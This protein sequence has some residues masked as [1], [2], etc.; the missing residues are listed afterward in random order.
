MFF[1]TGADCSGGWDGWI[2]IWWDLWEFLGSFFGGKLEA[3]A[4]Q[5]FWGF[6]RKKVCQVTLFESWNCLKTIGCFWK[7]NSGSQVCVC[8]IVSWYV[9]LA[10]IEASAKTRLKFEFLVCPKPGR[11]NLHGSTLTAPWIN[12]DSL[13]LLFEVVVPAFGTVLETPPLLRIDR[14]SVV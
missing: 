13:N 4:F 2:I 11:S 8:C 3:W 10:R 5:A 7:N 9:Q 14:K 1:S 12:F 6:E